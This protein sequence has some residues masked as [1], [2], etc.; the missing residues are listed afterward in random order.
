MTVQ[1]LI[2]IGFITVLLPQGINKIPLI[3]CEF[4]FI[5]KAI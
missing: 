1:A 4:K 3:L 2:P 5:Q